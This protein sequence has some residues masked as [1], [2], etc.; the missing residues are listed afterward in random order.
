M[1]GRRYFTVRSALL[2]TEH[3]LKELEGFIL[4][5]LPSLEYTLHCSGNVTLLPKSLDEILTYENAGFQRILGITIQASSPAI[6]DRQLE[7]E[8]GSP[9]CSVFAIAASSLH[10]DDSSWAYGFHTELRRRILASRPWYWPL[11]LFGFKIVLPMLLSLLPLAAT[12][13]LLVLELIGKYTPQPNSP[14][15]SHFENLYVLSIFGAFGVG[16]LL[17]LLKENFFPRTFFC[18]GR[19]KESFR[20][21]QGLLYFFFGVIA[22]GVAI[23]LVSSILEKIIAP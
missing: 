5:E 19:Q 2:I 4:K 6:Q 17:D 10:F 23:N 15:N 12:L 8:L 13:F 9:R 18:I 21:K 3:T 22:L 16:V 7:V 14:T 1:K 11:S 20:K